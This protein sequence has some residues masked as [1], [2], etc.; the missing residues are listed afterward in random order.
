MY[1]LEFPFFFPSL[2][3]HIYTILALS[4]LS[5]ILSVIHRKFFFSYSK[6]YIPLKKKNDLKFHFFGGVH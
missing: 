6:I 3:Q 5:F 2:I 1:F 4:L